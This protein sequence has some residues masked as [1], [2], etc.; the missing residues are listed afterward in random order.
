ML[1]GRVRQGLAARYEDLVET[2]NLP[3]GQKVGRRNEILYEEVVSA[4]TVCVTPENAWA[5]FTHTMSFYTICASFGN[6]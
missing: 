2:D 6:L 5:W 4:L 3:R 1:K